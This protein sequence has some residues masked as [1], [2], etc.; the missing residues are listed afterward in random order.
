MDDLEPGGFARMLCVEAAAASAPVRLAPGATWRGAQ[1][2]T[3][4]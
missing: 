1:E 2:L 4:G 3:A